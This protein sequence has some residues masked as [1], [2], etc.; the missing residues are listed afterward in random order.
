[1]G[2]DL[3]L[4]F[5]VGDR[6]QCRVGVGDDDWADGTVARLRYREEH[7]PKERVA[8]YQILLA[9]GKMIFAPIDDDRVVRALDGLLSKGKIPVTILT[10]FLGSGKTTLLNYILKAHHGKKYA[11]IENEIGAVGVDNILLKDAGYENQ[12][13]EETVTLLD[14]G[15]LCCTVRS[16][17]VGAIKGIVDKAKK[18]ASADGDDVSAIDGIL[19]E[20]T[21][22]A[23]PGP[24]CKTFYGDLFCSTYCKIDGVITLVDAVHFV[25]QLTRERSEGAV[26]ESAQQVAFADKVFL[27]KVDAASP[28]KLQ[29]VMEAIRGVNEFVPVTKCSFGKNPEAVPLEGLLAIDSYDIS[30]MAT[31]IDLSVCGTVTEANTDHGHDGGHGGGHGDGHGDGHGHGEG[32]D[33]GEDCDHESHG[34]GE[35]HGHGHGHAF[36]HDTGIGSFVCELLGKPVD[37]H[38]FNVFMRDLLE[39]SEN[40]YRYKGIIA[41]ASPHDGNIERRVL[42][43]VHD[44]V[45]L[46]N[47]EDWPADTPLK[48]QVVLIGRMLDKAKWTERWAETSV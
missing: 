17:L 43:G 8:P 32:H 24:I 5:K 33:C 3:E 19:I 20:T 13:T 38:K 44:M 6:V 10:G 15:C 45:D 4:R 16:D 26:N 28:E 21:G 27:N 22:V 37:F 30:K 34:H 12:F 18:Q 14:N 1:M 29:Q 9:D 42:Q 7:W 35:G 25:E 46:S 48:S 39:E 40:L 31:D 2:D 36:R 11:I 47:G 23:D 41:M